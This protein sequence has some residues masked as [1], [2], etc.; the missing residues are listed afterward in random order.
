MIRG[1]VL[2]FAF[3]FPDKTRPVV[4]LTR[5][6][7][8]PSLTKVTVAPITSTVRGLPSEFLLDESDGMK[9]LCAV[10]LHGVMTVPKAQL[11]KRITTLDARQMEAIC[12]ALRFALQCDCPA[13]SNA[14]AT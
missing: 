7:V 13:Y 1:D 4:I 8:G 5:D 12:R 14:N 10:N 6:S 3:P 11:G 9:T 2:L